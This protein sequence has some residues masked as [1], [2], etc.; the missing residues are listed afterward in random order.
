MDKII[1]KQILLGVLLCL[2]ETGISAQT[3]GVP[4]EKVL[5]TVAI[6]G[7]SYSTF[8]GYIPVGNQTYYTTTDWAKTGVTDV[9]QTWWWQV[10]REGGYKLGTNDSYS[11][12][13]ISFSGYNDE[14]YADRSFITRL[15]RLGNPDIILIF[16]GINDHWADVPIGEY[17][18]ENIKRA[19][20]YT[21]RPAVIKLLQM[22]QERFPNVQLYFVIGE[23]LKE[24]ITGSI[25][26]IC[27]HFDVP[28]V[29]L[30]GIETE[31][32][33]ATVQGMKDIARQVL[34]MMKDK[35]EK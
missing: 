6:L 29:L 11:G 12:A 26:E 17:K 4:R 30:K 23:N 1:V 21:F 31:S 2:F 35:N 22:S 8:E 18:Y 15:P 32:G 13:T 10:I 3:A 27:R 33:H 7:D 20:L 28:C 19:D 24:G 25:Q 5:Q 9:K 16:G 14:D 34:A